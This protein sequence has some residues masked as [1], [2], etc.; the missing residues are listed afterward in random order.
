MW[1]GIVTNDSFSIARYYIDNE[2]KNSPWTKYNTYPNMGRW[3]KTSGDMSNRAANTLPDYINEI[4]DRYGIISKDLLA[5]EKGLFKWSDIYTWL[6]NNEFNSGIKRGF[7][8]SGL[9]G[10]QFARDKEIELI[11]MQD[12]PQA[13]ESYI[14][15]C[16][17]D[18]AN[19]YKDILAKAAPVKTSK[20]HGTAIVFR[21][22]SPVM[23]VKEYGGSIQPLTDN[24]AVLGKAVASFIQAFHSRMLW[25][26]RKS[27]FMEYWIESAGEE[28]TC[29]IEDSPL[30]E[31][32]QE[33]GFDRGYS[34]I[35]LWR[36]SI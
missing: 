19:P 22:G 11:R 32:L 6:K 5:C 10:V 8:V 35:T 7:Y 4:L 29:K 31:K 14:T 30:Y 36:R 18:P 1:S 28:G 13:E 24:M 12:S 26:T 20:H 15:L 2:K 21:N 17:C 25:T 23:T 34:G 3:Y 33:L 16:S 9:S 27:I